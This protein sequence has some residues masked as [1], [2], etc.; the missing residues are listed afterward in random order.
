MHAMQ[1]TLICTQGLYFGHQHTTRPHK[2]CPPGATLFKMMATSR[3]L[4][5]EV[6]TAYAGDQELFK[7]HPGAGLL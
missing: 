1:V 2:R 6:V 3:H 5:V 4:S 7:D